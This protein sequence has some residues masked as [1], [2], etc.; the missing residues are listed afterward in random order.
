MIISP[1]DRNRSY[2]R[3]WNGRMLTPFVIVTDHVPDGLVDDGGSVEDFM[4]ECCHRWLGALSRAFSGE[5]DRRGGRRSQWDDC[6]S[7]HAKEGRQLAQRLRAQSHIRGDDPSLASDINK[8]AAAGDDAAA[9]T[10]DPQLMYVDKR[11][12]EDVKVLLNDVPRSRPKC[13]TQPTVQALMRQ[14]EANAAGLYFGGPTDQRHS[15]SLDAS[16]RRVRTA[17]F[18]GRLQRLLLAY[19]HRH[20]SPG[21]VVLFN[22]IFMYRSIRSDGME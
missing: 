6:F 22:M 21:Y 20:H 1:S 18:E 10:A 4:T 2:T 3:S 5:S 8:A 16:S 13:F 7:V 19:L 14:V 17:D 9:A 15:V 11:M 12:R